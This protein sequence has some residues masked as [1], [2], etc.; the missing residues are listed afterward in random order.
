MYLS[1][2][3]RFWVGNQI[4]SFAGSL[5]LSTTCLPG[6]RDEPVGINHNVRLAEEVRITKVDNIECNI[7]LLLKNHSGTKNWTKPLYLPAERWFLFSELECPAS[8]CQGL[9]D[10]HLCHSRLQV[11]GR[12]RDNFVVYVVSAVLFAVGFGFIWFPFYQH[13][14]VIILT[15]DDT[16]SW[17]KIKSKVSD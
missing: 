1:H 10:K 3:Y 11:W 12:S 17:L 9:A 7:V 8:K 5:R 6:A 2:P 4:T 13:N 14:A 15:P 16:S